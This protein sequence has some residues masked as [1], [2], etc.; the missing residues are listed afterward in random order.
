MF[1]RVNLRLTVVECVRKRR[2]G[3]CCVHHEKALGESMRLPVAPGC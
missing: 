2:K 1:L 3:N